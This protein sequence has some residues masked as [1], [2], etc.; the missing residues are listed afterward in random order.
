MNKKYL[1]L[2]ASLLGLSLAGQQAA[3][4]APQP[5]ASL[6][7]QDVEQVAADIDQV[8]KPTPA[9]PTSQPVAQRK[10]VASAPPLFERSAVR[11]IEKP[12]LRKVKY[13]KRRW[14]IV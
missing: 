8:R 1:L 6:T 7:A 5:A 11:F 13:G 14:V 12:H 2:G 9:K 3:S 10:V 4:T